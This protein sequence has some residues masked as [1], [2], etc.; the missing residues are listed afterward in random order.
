MLFLFWLIKK[1]GARF[2]YWTILDSF[3]NMITWQ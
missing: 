1:M 3:P 2:D